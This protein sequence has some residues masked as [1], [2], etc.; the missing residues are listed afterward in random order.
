MPDLAWELMMSEKVKPVYWIGSTLD[1]LKALDQE[2]RDRFG[3][4]LYQAQQGGIH[5]HA[6]PLKGLGSGVIE[7]VEDYDGNTFRAVYTAKFAN[8]IY[9]LHVFQK[10]SKKGA[11]TPKH[12]L[13]LITRRLKTAREHHENWKKTQNN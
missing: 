12:D 9:V 1:D 3:F 10:K 6:K 7:V 8:A 11:A 4:A 5:L 2:I 13:D